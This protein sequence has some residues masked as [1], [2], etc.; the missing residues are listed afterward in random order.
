MI[1]SFKVKNNN[2]KNT[3]NNYNQKKINLTFYNL[4]SKVINNK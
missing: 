4:I 1:I 2:Y 3:N